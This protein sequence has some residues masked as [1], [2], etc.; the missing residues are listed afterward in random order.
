MGFSKKSLIAGG[1]GLVLSIVLIAV[2]QPNTLVGIVIF[3]FLT[4]GPA[5]LTDLIVRKTSDKRNVMH[6]EVM[7][8]DG[9][10]EQ[11]KAVQ[12]ALSTQ[13]ESKD[14]TRILAAGAF[15]LCMDGDVPAA[16]IT[17]HGGV[18]KEKM[19]HPDSLRPD[20]LQQTYDAS[21]TTQG[22]ASVTGRAIAGAVVGGGVGAV[23]G[24]A[25]AEVANKN[26]GV[27]KN[28]MRT[29]YLVQLAIGDVM[30]SGYCISKAVTN[31]FGVPEYRSGGF[32]LE[33]KEHYYLLQGPFTNANTP[34]Q[35]EGIKYYKEYFEKVIPGVIRR[36]DYN[37]A[38]VKKQL[39][40]KHL[41]DKAK[42]DA[43][44]ASFKSV[45]DAQTER[46]E[47][48]TNTVPFQK[49]LFTPVGVKIGNT[50]IPKEQIKS[51]TVNNSYTTNGGMMA[52]TDAAG[53]QHLA[54]YNKKIYSS[55][56]RSRAMMGF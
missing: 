53:K 43:A 56:C 47:I 39:E 14:Y 17:R 35:R 30:Y 23:V 24:A 1:I 21:Y 44:M 19:I 6:E 22:K 20:I 32:S 40:E 50:Y 46:I 29:G 42:N 3:F 54:G 49:W 34:E 48:A 27:T 26:G 10:A 12:E 16:A 25:S 33:E 28:H 36:I 5:G 4:L 38:E 7:Q 52:L 8:M 11:E 45:F 9:G 31:Y 55:V 51:F 13:G 37:N 15:I 18:T 41:A 2:L